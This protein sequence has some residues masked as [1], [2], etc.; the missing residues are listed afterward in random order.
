MDDFEAGI[1]PVGRR[2][3]QRTNESEAEVRSRSEAGERGA[4]EA[5]GVTDGDEQGGGKRR[6]CEEDRG[7]VQDP[8]P[9]ALLGSSG[10]MAFQLNRRGRPGGRVVSSTSESIDL[11]NESIQQISG[12]VATKL[13][14]ASLNK[15]SALSRGPCAKN[16][17]KQALYSTLQ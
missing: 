5:P 15:H 6:K 12:S 8:I 13:P 2:A 14:L 3:P 17:Q 7:G 10:I 9:F 11:N 4:E 1:Q 16:P